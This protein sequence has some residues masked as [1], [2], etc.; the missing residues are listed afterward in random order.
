MVFMSLP[1]IVIRGWQ[2]SIIVGSVVVVAVVSMQDVLYVT[3][4]TD[5]GVNEAL[6]AV[7]T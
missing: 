1:A 7:E 4:Q 5:D 6:V 3:L 2:I